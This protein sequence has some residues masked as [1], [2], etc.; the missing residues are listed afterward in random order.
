MGDAAAHGATILTTRGDPPRKS[1]ARNRGED[2]CLLHR[3][4]SVAL[5]MDHRS[6]AEDH[7]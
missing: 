1:E 7:D 4:A 2:T 3:A 6:R 5:A